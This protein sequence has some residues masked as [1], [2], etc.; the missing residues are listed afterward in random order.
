VIR[1]PRASRHAVVSASSAVA[2]TGLLAGA[3]RILP[4]LLDPSVPWSVA[5]PF[6][7]G[8]SAVAFESALL[9]GWPIGWA[10]ACFRLVESGEARVLQSLGERPSTTVARLRL[11]GA[12][13]G[14]ALAAVAVVYGRDA[15]APGRVA[16]ELVERARASCQAAR[17]HVTYSV[18]FTDFT[19]LCVEGRTAR[20]VGRVPG[21]STAV[22][23]AKD[24]RIAGDFRVVELDDARI[25]IAGVP[26][27]ALHAGSLSIRGLAPWAQASSISA[28]L[29]GLVLALSGLA[30][31]TSSAY[32]VLVSP[33]RTRVGALCF[34]AVGPLAA[35]GWLRLL[36]RGGAPPWE[37]TIVPVA[38]G[39]CPVIFARALALRR[40]LRGRNRAAT[41]RRRV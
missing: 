1:L 24:A 37:F 22:L 23:S 7:R 39:A 10:L 6:A 27:T 40:R 5:E 12:A 25:S 41:T 35:L 8:L 4:W 33:I 34:G 16:T 32:C 30:A 31:A 28:L 29:R 15:S 14:V 9:S 3:V 19:W 36:E 18:P 38:A 20:L 21:M 11:Q 2:L 17:S 13:I 26:Q